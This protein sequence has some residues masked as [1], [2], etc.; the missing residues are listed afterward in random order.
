[1]KI[2]KI[3]KNLKT[4]IF[5]IDSTLYTNEAYA[6]EQVDIQLRHFAKIKNTTPENIRKMIEDF[7]SE[8]TRTH[9]GKKISLGN[10]LV[11]FGV[12]IEESI[13]WRKTLLEPALFLKKDEKLISVLT[14]LKEKY[15][16]I[17]VTNN[18]VLPA[19]KPLAAIGIEKL[20]PDI[21]GLD[22]TYKS[23]PSLE[24]LM[25]A[26]KKTNAGVEEC[27]SVGDR[28]DIDLSLAL[29]IGM[30]GILVDGVDDVYKFPEILKA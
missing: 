6:T 24:P 15:S 11:H 25:L 26:A 22:T 12:S 13:N 28:F 29:E 14:Q 20:I 1:M 9:N 23:K 16:L 27:L 2:Y 18:P 7:R 4:I 30:G 17:C 5:D 8:Y 3:P 21:I 19:Y 10:T